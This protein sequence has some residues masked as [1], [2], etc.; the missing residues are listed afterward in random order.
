VAPTGFDS[1]A[2]LFEVAFEGLA[3]TAPSP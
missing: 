3:L 1:Q 2:S